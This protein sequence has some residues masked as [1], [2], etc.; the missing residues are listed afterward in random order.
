MM[1]TLLPY[2]STRGRYL[3]A[4]SVLLAV[5]LAF[6]AIG[7]AQVAPSSSSPAAQSADQTSSDTGSSL[8]A[9]ARKA[10][11]QNPTHAKKVFTDEDMELQAGP[12]PRLKMDGAENADDVTAAIAKYKL[13]HTPQETEDVV[14]AWY[15]RYDSELAAAIQA[16]LDTT[17][18]RAANINN[19]YE[20]CQQNQ[21]YEDY[22]HCR[23][24]QMAEQRGAQHDRTEISNN[25]NVVVRIQHSFM[26][27][28]VGLTQN[29][30]RYDWF[31]VRTT[32]NID[33]F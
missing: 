22:Q 17:S 24:R 6:S 9:A 3:A 28:R 16:N 21:D 29:G 18:L 32:N 10:K 33:R 19:G 13:S 12:L 30:L 15:D 7:F 14:R 27:I 31:K 20:L 11:A 4:L 1:R 23:N 8:A 2:R 25:T 26:K 5:V